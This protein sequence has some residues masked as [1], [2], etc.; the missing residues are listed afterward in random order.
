MP[1]MDGRAFFFR[2]LS[3][4]RFFVVF[5]HRTNCNDNDYEPIFEMHNYFIRNIISAKAVAIFADFPR[6]SNFH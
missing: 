2:I 3:R 6:S 5:A 1:S 4:I